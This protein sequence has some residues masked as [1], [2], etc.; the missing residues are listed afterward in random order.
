MPLLHFFSI[1]RRNLWRKS[2]KE[3]FT[4]VQQ[5]QA[6]I[7]LRLPIQLLGALLFT[8]L[9]IS[10]LTLYALNGQRAVVSETLRKS[11]EQSLALLANHLEQSLL[12]AI[13]APFLVLKNL[14]WENISK[15]RLYL[16]R[17]TF[18]AVERVLFLDRQMALTYSFPLPL[19]E[20]QRHFNQWIVQRVQEEAVDTEHQPLH[21]F[22]ETVAGRLAVFAFQ[23]VTDLPSQGEEAKDA[24][25]S[26]EGWMLMHFNLDALK[27][28]RVISLLAEFNQA[29][30]VSVHLQ[31]PE[32]TLGQDKLSFPLTRVLPGWL[33]ILDPPEHALDR[34]LHHQSWA[35]IGVASTALLAIAITGFAVWWEIRHEYAL[36][37]LR[38]RFVAN[39]SHE[40]KTPLSLIRMYAETL[41]LQ[42][43][44]NLPKQHE[45]HRVI[46]RESERLSRMI[47]N[48]L[49]FA[50]LSTGAEAYH[51]TETD[52]RATVSDILERYRPQFEERGVRIEVSLQ[53]QL[54]P[55]AHD[56]HGI[57]QVLL[58]LLDNA[59][60]YAASGGVVR[61]CL[62][63]DLDWV[64]L[65][66]IDFGPGIP[67]GLQ[68]ARRQAF[69]RDRLAEEAQGSGL[70]LALV[71][72]IALAHHAH[73]IL[74]KPDDHT[75]IK[76]VVSFPSYK[77]KP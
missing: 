42:R 27:A 14:P 70:G 54:P 23:P 45:Y 25:A 8:T 68:G 5:L 55:V 24:D 29:H 57:T 74:D 48:V 2:S 11:Q 66:V 22:I 58:N 43:L 64:E 1:A 39:V 7:R 19:D 10:A 21:V 56:P 46:L 37:E 3:G 40:L 28:S 76:A 34:W 59:V 69:Q 53:G 18:P 50:R 35:I 63:G 38:N 15:E 71:E 13:Q 44:T 49:D 26:P 33:L 36:V 41:Y 72:E 20:H 12:Q 31:N 17:Q 62:L 30:G 9:S 47:N 65:Q 75:G 51:L 77:D 4:V 61:V 16:L 67:A 6:K 73:F 32:F 60:K 52:L